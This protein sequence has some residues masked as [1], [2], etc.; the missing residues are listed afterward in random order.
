MATYYVATTGNDSNPGSS[1][2][3]WLTIQHAA[4][5]VSAGDTVMVRDGI[6]TG[7]TNSSSVDITTSGSS[8]NFIKFQ[9]VNL[10]GA[11]I[12]GQSN[13]QDFGFRMR[14][15]FI[16]VNGFEIYGMLGAGCY[17][18]EP[19]TSDFRIIHC[20]FHDIGRDC[21][22]GDTGLVGIFTRQPRTYID[23]CLFHDI[24]RYADGEH[25]CS[26]QPIPPNHDHGIYSAADGSGSDQANELTI[27]NCIFWN[28]TEGWAIQIDKGSYHDVIIAN[29]TFATYNPARLGQILFI[30]IGT[31]TT[32][33]MRNNLHFSPNDCGVYFFDGLYVSVTMV[34]NL[35]YNGN[36]TKKES[37]IAPG[38]TPTGTVTGNPLF[39]DSGSDDYRILSGSPAANAGVTLA[40]VTTDIRGFARPFSTSYDI[41]AYEYTLTPPTGFRINR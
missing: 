40:Y 32:M 27:I 30:D 23:G 15:S 8:G 36:L 2:S 41:G 38:V 31:I 37:G 39:V 18:N 19:G 10:Y 6:Y 12:N 5:S 24:G 28:L 34:N 11:K 26:P 4:D 1:G 7:N 25:G 14:A 20:H 33:T 17:V 21:F 3:P 9:S 29:C 13:A 35:I 22:T 16:E